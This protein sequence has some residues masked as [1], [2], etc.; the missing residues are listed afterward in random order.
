M[1]GRMFDLLMAKGFWAAKA[2]MTIMQ[3]EAV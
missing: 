1:V 2:I 3:V